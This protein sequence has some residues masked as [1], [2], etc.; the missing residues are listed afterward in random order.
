MQTKIENIVLIRTAATDLD[1]QGRFCGQLDV[2]LCDVGVQ[3]SHFTADQL[4]DFGIKII[5]RAPCMAASQMGKI[6]GKSWGA[7]QKIEPSLQNIDYG[8]W[9]GRKLTDLK[10]TQPRVYRSWMEHPETICPPN[11]EPIHAVCQ[12]TGEFLA[13]LL[14]KSCNGRVAVLA[15]API[16]SI[17]AAKLGLGEIEEFWEVQEP[18]GAWITPGKTEFVNNQLFSKTQEQHG[19][20]SIEELDLAKYPANH[21]K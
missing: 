7:K 17:L 19:R 2:P 5:Y 8:L 3:Q 10:E 4:H 18:D 15:S 1:L 12:R 6:L 20:R 21:G 16:T 11:G 13:K 14:Q 9:H